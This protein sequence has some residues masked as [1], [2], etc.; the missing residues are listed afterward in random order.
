MKP[1]SRAFRWRPHRNSPSAP[2]P[3]TVRRPSV[4]ALTDANGLVY[5]GARITAATTAGGAVSPSV[6]ITDASGQASFQWTPGSAAVNTL[7][8]AVE[9][10]PSVTLRLNAG[11]AVPVIG[12][13]VNA[14]TSL[15]G[16]APG[17]IDTIYGVNL[18]DAAVSLNGAPVTLLYRGETQINFYVP[19]E[20][21]LGPGTLTV[22][23]AAGIAVSARVTVT[24]ADPGIFAIVPEG[25]YLV[26]YCTGL[27]PTHPSGGFS[28]T[29]VVPAVY[30]GATALPRPSA[31]SRPGSRACIKSTCS[32]RRA[33]TRYPAGHR[34]Q[35]TTVQQHGSSYASID[36]R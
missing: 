6:A 8:V 36:I 23:N 25:D 15:P 21:A 7:T 31:A 19:P 32:C 34:H 16:M 27:G 29:T 24:A 20:A 10:A 33:R 5:A 35:R 9:A 3:A 13:V 2:F 14:A 18:A 4:V 1:P 11:T 17:S 28:V 22:T 12:A 26:I 30:V